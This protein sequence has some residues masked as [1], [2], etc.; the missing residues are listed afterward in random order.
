[1][2]F[3]ALRR[4]VLRVLPFCKK[5]SFAGEHRQFVRQWKQGLR[6]LRF[7]VLGFSPCF[8][9]F[10]IFGYTPNA[11]VGC[12]R[13]VISRCRQNILSLDERRKN[14]EQ[15]YVQR[16]CACRPR[17]T[18]SRERTPV[19]QQKGKKISDGDG[20]MAV[21]RIAALESSLGTMPERA[22]A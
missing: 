9:Y 6:L 2:R 7:K 4:A 20:K 18:W 11:C 15:E 13:A 12:G 10:A 1:M 17:G 8:F 14:L 16:A 5:E 21:E 19:R 22:E 3:A